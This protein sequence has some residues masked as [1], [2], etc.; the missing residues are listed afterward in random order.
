MISIMSF[1]GGGN[2]FCVLSFQNEDHKIVKRKFN[3][4]PS[5]QFHVEFSH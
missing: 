3:V 5:F 1:V 2:R 4:V